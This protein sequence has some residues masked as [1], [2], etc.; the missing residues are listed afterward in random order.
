MRRSQADLH[1]ARPLEVLGQSERALARAFDEAEAMDAVLVMD[2]ADSLLEARADGAEYGGRT[3]NH[4]VN[5]LLRRLD[6]ASGV[7]IL[8]TNRTSALDPAL[9]RRLTARLTFPM[10]DAAQRAEIL[11]RHTPDGVELAGDV[12]LAELARS[13]PLSGAHLR[14]A[15]LAAIRRMVLRDPA[16]RTLERAL[17]EEAL[18]EVASSG[19]VRAIGFRSA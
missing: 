17:L 11:R 3:A 10:P 8:I 19:A 18:V 9:E 5:I 1:R 12:D 4:L 14:N 6:E 2:E 13:H 16:Q 7:A 15:M